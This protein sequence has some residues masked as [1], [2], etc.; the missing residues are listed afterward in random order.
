MQVG[1]FRGLNGY[2][3]RF[4]VSAVAGNNV[5]LQGYNP[6]AALNR[7]SGYLQNVSY[8]F[9]AASSFQGPSENSAPGEKVSRLP[10]GRRKARRS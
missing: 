2:R 4:I 8:Q 6:P 10:V 3:G 1:G 5:T 7:V 9:I